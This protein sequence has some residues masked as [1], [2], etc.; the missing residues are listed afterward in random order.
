MTTILD[1]YL[2]RAFATAFAFCAALF[3]GLFVVVDF[4]ARQGAFAPPGAD[5]TH[6][7]ILSRAALWYSYR[8]PALFQ[9]TAPVV[10]LAAAMLTVVQMARGNEL[11]AAVAAGRSLFRL[12][13]PLLA[14]A[15]F[16][17]ALV[18][19]VG[20]WALPALREAV[21]ERGLDGKP[22]AVRFA[23]AAQDRLGA[24]FLIDAYNRENR[25]MEHVR[26]RLPLRPDS[27]LFGAGPV[28]PGA[29]EATVYA[30]SLRWRDD[31]PGAASPAGGCWMVNEGALAFWDATG[32]RV[33]P[34]VVLDGQPLPLTDLRPRDI[35]VPVKVTHP[36]LFS[37]PGPAPGQRRERLALHA[38]LARPVGVIVLLLLGV[39]LL[40]LRERVNAAAGVALAVGASAVYFAAT[41]FAE[42]LGARGLISPAVAVWGPQGALLAAGA[43][44]VTRMRT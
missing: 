31:P 39:P 2:L 15:A 13:L 12:L 4:F 11:V 34:P 20:E 3:I 8:V 28:P 1:R 23:F 44:L 24:R 18:F 32:A 16:V 42:S 41:L 9:Q 14:G 43:A 30:R 27:A 36:A 38:T 33:G 10:T 21:D 5:V 29:A 19:T 22:R 25:V 40:F 17:A 6:G 7:A 26:L 35:N 37:G